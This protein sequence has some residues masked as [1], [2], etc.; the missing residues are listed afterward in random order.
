[1]T[2]FEAPFVRVLVLYSNTLEDPGVIANA[3]I[4]KSQ[5]HFLDAAL[6]RIRKEKYQGALIIADHHPPYTVAPHGWSVELLAQID[7]VCEENGVWPHAF[8]S[9]HAHNY[10]RFTRT[11]NA[12]GTRIPYLI[13]GNGG[14]GLAKLSKH[15]DPTLRAPQVIQAASAKKDQVVLESYDDS[16]YGYLRIVVTQA[17]LRI[18]Y[19]ATTDGTAAKS[20][21]DH[22][23]VDLATRKIAHFAAPDLGRTALAAEARAR[24][25]KTG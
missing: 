17:Q 9:G 2:P 3:H 15:G 22:V 10:Q 14:H 16:H 6:K 11:R 5:I 8:L 12:D 4:G 20:P 21:G 19:H 25:E 13:C 18:E 7:R 23:T 1:M 24:F